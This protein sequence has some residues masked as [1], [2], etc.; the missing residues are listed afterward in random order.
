MY[1]NAC[2]FSYCRHVLV[3][4]PARRSI[5][6]SEGIKCPS[7]IEGTI[8]TLEGCRAHVCKK[9]QRAVTNVCV[10]IHMHDTPPRCCPLGGGFEGH[11]V[12]N[13]ITAIQTHRSYDIQSSAVY[14]V[15]MW[16]IYL[17]RPFCGG[18]L[19]PSRGKDRGVFQWS[20]LLSQDMNPKQ[21]THIC[22]LNL[23]LEVHCT[24]SGAV[25]SPSF[26]RLLLAPCLHVARKR[27]KTKLIRLKHQLQCM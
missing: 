20:A 7:A 2:L 25:L 8:N 10:D 26:L 21:F 4:T 13:L 24:S 12:S 3:I 9:E 1:D 18:L 23:M 27:H 14:G 16:C 5:S 19:H 17:S 22:L 15:Q 11:G 6:G